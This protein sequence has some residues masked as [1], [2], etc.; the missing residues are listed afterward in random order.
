MCVNDDVSAGRIQAAAALTLLSFLL[1]LSLSLSLSLRS[2]ILTHFGDTQKAENPPPSYFAI[3]RRN[4]NNKN[5]F[6][7]FGFLKVKLVFWAP[8]ITFSSTLHVDP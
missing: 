6:C 2:L 8:K 3:D 7:S 1:S 5:Y 4:A